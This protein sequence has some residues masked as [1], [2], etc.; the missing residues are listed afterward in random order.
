MKPN[1][2]SI[3]KNKTTFFFEKKIQNG[4]LKKSS[5]SSSANSQYFFTNISWIG[6]LVSRIDWCKGHFYTILQTTVHT[7]IFLKTSLPTSSFVLKN[8]LDKDNKIRNILI[9]NKLPFEGSYFS[10]F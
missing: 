1:V 3:G 9:V 6:P 5:F 10:F 2:V 4:R 7:D 8:K